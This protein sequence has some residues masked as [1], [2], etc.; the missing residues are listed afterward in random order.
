MDLNSDPYSK[1][2]NEDFNN[3]LKPIKNKIKQD[4]SI[5][6]EPINTD[7]E[8]FDGAARHPIS[9]E[10][11]SQVIK[12]RPG[13]AGNFYDNL[14]KENAERK[15]VSDLGMPVD[16]QPVNEKYEEYKKNGLNTWNRKLNKGDTVRVKDLGDED[17]TIN[18]FWYK[19]Q[20]QDDDTYQE[21]KDNLWHDF[22]GVQLMDKDGK[23]FNINAYQLAQILNGDK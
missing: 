6:S 19:Q 22:R 14:E 16:P 3:G 11:R 10:E 7:N 18:G 1:E 13:L 5:G 12:K 17:F 20:L 15:E 8:P 4:G 9:N 21:G 23:V 2:F